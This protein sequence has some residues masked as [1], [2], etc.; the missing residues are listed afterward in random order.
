[1]VLEAEGFEV[2]MDDVRKSTPLSSKP[3]APVDFCMA[4]GLQWNGGSLGPQRYPE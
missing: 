2:E 3:P 1:M 4:L